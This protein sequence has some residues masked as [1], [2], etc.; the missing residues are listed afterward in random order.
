V[1]RVELIDPYGTCYAICTRQTETILKAW[2]DEV[3]PYCWLKGRPGD[4]FDVIWPHVS[5][6]PMWAWKAS[7]RCDDPDWLTDS[8]A[9]GRRMELRATDG[10][11]G[12]AELLRI[13]RELERELATMNREHPRD[14]PA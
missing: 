9:L 2:F 3:L 14:T 7:T 8:R 5:V 13:R 4:D 6:W 12:L 1:P 11:S 10:A